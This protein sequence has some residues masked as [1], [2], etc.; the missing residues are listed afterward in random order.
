MPGT[1]THPLFYDE[2]LC[3]VAES[4]FNVI[5][6]HPVSHGKSPRERKTF[7]FD[8]MLRNITDAVSFAINRYNENILLGGSSQ[9][10]ILVI[11][12]AAKER[13]IRAVFPQNLM[14]PDE[15][16]TFDITRF[17][18]V[19]KPL[20]PI[21]PTLARFAARV[22]P[23]L[24]IPITFYIK[25]E[26]ISV[27]RDLLEQFAYD[28]IGLTSY[29]LGFLSSLIS[30]DMS[31]ITDGS[32]RCPVVVIAAAGDPLFPLD[33]TK[34]VFD[35]IKAPHKELLLFDEKCHMIL[36][37]KCDCVADRIIGKLK[38]YAVSG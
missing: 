1:M 18:K 23:R 27:S 22:S 3:A 13:R 33:Y 29:P 10:G 31:G 8:D 32:I 24:P 26:R 28:P 21:I 9:G 5:G 19:F 12:A 2:F 35:R 34:K 37:E 36:V 15:S 11:A 7:T 16:D 20:Y 17:P 38:E 4:G 6:I 14:L 25:P 30:A